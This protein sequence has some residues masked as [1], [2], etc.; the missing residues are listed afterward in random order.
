MILLFP[1]ICQKALAN[2][3]HYLKFDLAIF[4]FFIVNLNKT[5]KNM[6]KK[7]YNTMVTAIG[8]RLFKIEKS[9]RSGRISFEK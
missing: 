4:C 6:L 1:V 3:L 2:Y 5:E 9:L 7:I 8:L